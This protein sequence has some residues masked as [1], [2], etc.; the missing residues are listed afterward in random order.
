MNERIDAKL[1]KDS[2]P[3]SLDKDE[4]EKGEI[5][6]SRKNGPNTEDYKNWYMVC[7]V[8]IKIIFRNLKDLTK[9]NV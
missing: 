5:E 4:I 6:S 8:H 9:N 1:L 2:L 3:V 7:F